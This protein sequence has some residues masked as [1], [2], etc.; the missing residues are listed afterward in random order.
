M[1]PHPPS[2]PEMLPRAGKKRQKEREKDIMG[3]RSK[4][5]SIPTAR[6]PA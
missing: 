5:D 2:Q 6:L 3:H 4:W 1:K